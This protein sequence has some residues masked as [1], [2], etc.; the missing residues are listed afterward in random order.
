LKLGH[1]IDLCLCAASALDVVSEVWPG[2]EDK[3]LRGRNLSAVSRTLY[4]QVGKA[5]TGLPSCAGTSWRVE[6]QSEKSIHQNQQKPKKLQQ[7]QTVIT[8]CPILRGKYSPLE[9]PAARKIENRSEN[10]QFWIDSEK[11]SDF[12]RSSFTFQPAQGSD[13]PPKFKK[14]IENGPILV[15]FARR[16][17]LFPPPLSPFP[18]VPQSIS[19]D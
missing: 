18:P 4:R 3:A 1:K 8:P 5:F 9:R 17:L 11:P 13:S 16:P 7:T 15:S 14:R 2:A 12:Q 6:N 19:E 10:G